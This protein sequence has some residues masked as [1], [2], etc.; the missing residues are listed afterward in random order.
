METES[1]LKPCCR[2]WLRLHSEGVEPPT[3][4]SEVC[5]GLNDWNLVKY[6]AVFRGCFCG[7]LRGCV[8]LLTVA[9]TWLGFGECEPQGL[10]ELGGRR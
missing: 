8:G 2:N 7:F 10:G 6:T 1:Q 9:L 5:F 4:G 3:Y